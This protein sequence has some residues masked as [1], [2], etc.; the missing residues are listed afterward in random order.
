M[1]CVFSI[2]CSSTVLTVVVLMLLTAVRAS[3][4]HS[5]PNIILIVADDLGE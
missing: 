3:S 1:R 2:L 5:Q 4:L